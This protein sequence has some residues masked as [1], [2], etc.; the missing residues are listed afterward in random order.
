MKVT[1]MKFPPDLVLMEAT[2]KA[3]AHEFDSISQTSAVGRP[4]SKSNIESTLA[5]FRQFMDAEKYVDILYLL[6]TLKD[7]NSFPPMVHLIVGFT[8]FKMGMVLE[9]IKHLSIALE[10]EEYR[11]IRGQY[12]QLIGAMLAHLGRIDD[13]MTV[14]GEF[15]DVVRGVNL[16]FGDVMKLVKIFQDQIIQVNSG[17]LFRP[18]AKF[19]SLEQQIMNFKA[20]NK[21][22]EDGTFTNYCFQ[23]VENINQAKYLLG[24]WNIGKKRND[25]SA[26]NAITLLSNAIVII[27]PREIYQSMLEL[28]P[29]ILDYT[30]SIV[31]PTPQ[32]QHVRTYSL[33]KKKPEPPD[34][35]LEVKMS[36]RKLVLGFLALLKRNYVY[37]IKEF[38]G[39]IDILEPLAD[40]ICNQVKC[41]LMEC[42]TMSVPNPSNRIS[43]VMDLLGYQPHY[44]ANLFLAECHQH[45]S[46]EGAT[47]I[48][49]LK[50]DKILRGKQLLSLNLEEAIINCIK[51]VIHMKNDDPHIP[52]V[53]DKI[54]VSLLLLGGVNYHVFV[55]FVKL[56]DHFARSAQYNHLHIFTDDDPEFIN[57]YSI[58]DKFVKDSNSLEEGI[59]KPEARNFLPQ[60]ILN[61]DFELLVMEGSYRVLTTRKFKSTSSFY[62]T[63]IDSDSSM[64]PTVEILENKINTSQNIAQ[65]CWNGYCNGELPPHIQQ[66]YTQNLNI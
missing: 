10:I 15:I 43:E 13:V 18:I 33:F 64:P 30:D 1:P 36:Q 11:S 62:I 9:G 14:F 38:S 57:L 53:Y 2:T 54:L 35:S 17:L 28:E 12:L 41:L 21:T 6:P 25:Q 39:V 3:S 66:Y 58:I 45:L 4:S 19:P 37:A 52:I 24:N 20:A 61:D 29:V 56:R 50:P 59:W 63:P 26:D 5:Q 44:K 47:L 48:T 7:F 16:D 27:G 22:F 31:Q 23:I 34:N 51:C 40:P 49:I 8:F 42:K 46:I 65:I 32:Q 60:V 55:F